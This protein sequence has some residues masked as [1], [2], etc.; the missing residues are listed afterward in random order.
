MTHI[1]TRN[2]LM[3]F[4]EDN[5]PSPSV[6]RAMQNGSTLL[7]GAFG[8]MSYTGK[9]CWIVQ[10]TSTHNKTW[11][12]AI[13]EGFTHNFRCH[14]INEPS[15]RYWIGDVNDGEL[16]TGDDPEEFRRLKNEAKE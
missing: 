4:L 11:Y 14:F 1:R 10:V 7:L 6:A 13:L 8:K 5:A 9:L 16:N 12:I 2:E 15:W 3:E